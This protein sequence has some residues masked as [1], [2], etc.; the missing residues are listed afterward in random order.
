MREELEELSFQYLHP[1]AYSLV[2]EKLAAMS[3][4]SADMISEI[5]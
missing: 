5:E 3:E 4:K 1:E 2:H